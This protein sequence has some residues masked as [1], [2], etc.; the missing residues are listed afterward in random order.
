MRPRVLPFVRRSGVP[1]LY[2]EPW[3]LDETGAVH[4]AEG[5]TIAEPVGCELVEP[6]DAIALR[7]IVA[8]VNVCD[9]V[10]GPELAR[11][12]REIGGAL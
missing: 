4:N 2:G 8:C 3:R 7:R 9:G 5:V 11:V 12:A 1:G 10:T 6:D